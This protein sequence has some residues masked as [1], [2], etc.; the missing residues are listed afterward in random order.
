MA[1]GKLHETK[2]KTYI[3]QKA[4]DTN[5]TTIHCDLV[6]NISPRLTQRLHLDILATYG[7]LHPLMKIQA[8]LYNAGTD[9]W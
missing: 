9:R 5:M 8:T 3:V 4:G 7:C 6:V 1:R 2:V